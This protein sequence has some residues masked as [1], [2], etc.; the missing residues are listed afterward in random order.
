MKLSTRKILILEVITLACVLAVTFGVQAGV[1][2]EYLQII[3]LISAILASIVLLGWARPRNQNAKNLAIII[4]LAAV[5]FQVTTFVLLGIKQGFLANIYGWNLSSIS[6]VFL[7][8]TLLIIAEEIFRGQMLEKGK[9]S[10][11]VIII[12][13]AIVWAIEIYVILPAY[14][15]DNPRNIFDL[16]M[17]VSFPALLKN[18]MLT[19]LALGYDY[20]IG[21][22]YRLIMELPII[23][24]PIW[25]DISNYLTAIFQTMFVVMILIVL[26]ISHHGYVLSIAV[27]GRPKKV[28][29]AETELQRQLKKFSKITL[30]TIVVGIMLVYVALMSGIFKYYFLA[31]GSG[32]MEPTLYRGDMILVEKTDDYENIQ[33]GEV[34]VYQHGEI[35]VVH[36]IQEKRAHGNQYTF[37]TKGDANAE[38]D[39]WVI[40]QKDIIGIVKGKITAFGFPTLWFNELF[41][42]EKI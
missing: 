15:L 4:L 9:T 31:V 32:S 26:V 16:V 13:T 21:L 1:L 5:L 39:S 24:L 37:V 38:S 30:W 34:L 7:P 33:E 17:M 22:G 36:R 42:G 8:A 28:S 41:N 18:V 25:P 14:S 6:K 35:I 40:P 20:R 23:I 27:S 10:R 2:R 3:I 19:F 29:Q 12:T 11:A